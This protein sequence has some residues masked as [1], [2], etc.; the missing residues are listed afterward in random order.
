M[1][2]VGIT[3]DQVAAQADALVGEGFNEPTILAVR[4][5]LGKTGS[6]NCVF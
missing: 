4:D 6:P 1:A 3:Y 2:R 5:R